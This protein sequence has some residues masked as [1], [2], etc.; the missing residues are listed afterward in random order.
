[1]TKA[2]TTLKTIRQNAQVQDLTAPAL[3]PKDAPHW[4]TGRDGSRFIAFS[5]WPRTLDELRTMSRDYGEAAVAE[6]RWGGVHLWM[7]KEEPSLG[8]LRNP[9]PVVQTSIAM[10]KEHDRYH[11]GW[12]HHDGKEWPTPVFDGLTPDCQREAKLV[13]A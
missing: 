13:A 11:L 6:A 8:G 5:V 2:L 10:M 9:Y 1:M 4:M 7:M 3:V 12:P